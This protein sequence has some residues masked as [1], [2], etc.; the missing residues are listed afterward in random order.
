MPHVSLDQFLDICECEDPDRV[1]RAHWE[2]PVERLPDEVTTFEFFMVIPGGDDVDVKEAS[3]LLVG[4]L[5]AFCVRYLESLAAGHQAHEGRPP[6]LRE[7]VAKIQKIHSASHQHADHPVSMYSVAMQNPTVAQAVTNA[8]N[9]RWN[10][11]AKELDDFSMFYPHSSEP[12][13]AL[14][15]GLPGPFGRIPARAYSRAPR[16]TKE[17][18]ITEKPKSGK[19]KH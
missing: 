19:S 5:I 18:P 11:G 1:H 10:N 6:T 8:A 9:N 14:S 16:S 3:L 2:L 7:L 15:F 4:K 12:T 17:G 13:Q